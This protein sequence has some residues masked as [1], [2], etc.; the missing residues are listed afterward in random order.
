MSISIETEVTAACDNPVI[1]LT[2]RLSPIANN[3]VED[4]ECEDIT[5]TINVMDVMTNTPI[6]DNLVA[7]AI[8][9]DANGHVEARLLNLELQTTVPLTLF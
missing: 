3:T 5:M 2:L 1:H 9:T 7:S 4:S 8:K 6:N